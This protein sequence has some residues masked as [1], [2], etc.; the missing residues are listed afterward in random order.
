MQSKQKSQNKNKNRKQINKNG[1]EIRNPKK[2]KKRERWRS[3]CLGD[4]RKRANPLWEMEV[5][6]LVLSSVWFL[7]LCRKRNRPTLLFPYQIVAPSTTVL[8]IY[9][10]PILHLALVTSLTLYR[11]I[12]LFSPY[13]N[14]CEV[15]RHFESN[16]ILFKC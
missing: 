11:Q 12:F 5:R 13:I 16:Q 14:K 10:H 6:S 3:S 7:V 8:R 9:T 15:Q 1:G 2:K 4:S